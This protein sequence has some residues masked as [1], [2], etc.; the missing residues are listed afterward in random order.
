[1]ALHRTHELSYL[2]EKSSEKEKELIG[3]S[4][5]RRHHWHNRDRISKNSVLPPA[6]TTIKPI[7]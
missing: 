3:K 1:L 7:Q 6:L 5:I 2:D 4:V